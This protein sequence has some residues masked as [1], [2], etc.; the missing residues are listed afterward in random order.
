MAQWIEHWPA[1]Q[2]VTGSIPSADTC[3]VLGQ[4]P[5]RGC[6]RDNHTLVFLLFSFT[7]LS[8]LSRNK[9]FFK[10]F[11]LIKKERKE[12]RY[13]K[14][15][16]N[17]TVCSVVQLSLFF[18]PSNQ[19]DGIYATLSFIPGSLDTGGKPTWSRSRD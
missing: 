8:P 4:V 2:R 10:R 9:I 16:I 14:G 17:P 11:F 7:L 3:L 6:K 19:L 12:K 18:N 1:N 13:K 15:M 5:S